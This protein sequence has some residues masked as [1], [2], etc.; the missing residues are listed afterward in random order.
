[1][2]NHCTRCV[3]PET[4]ESLSFDAEGVCSVCHQIEYKHEAIDWDARGAEFDRILENVRGKYD[5]DCIVPFSGGCPSSK[6]LG[7][8]IV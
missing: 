3:M 7:Q 5:Y 2:L 8:L 4:A 6:F 1:M